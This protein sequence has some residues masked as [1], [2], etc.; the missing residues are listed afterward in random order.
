MV[1]EARRLLDE[2]IQSLEASIRFY[3]PEA[4]QERELWVVKSFLRNLDPAYPEDA[5]RS[6]V[7]DPPDVLFQDARFEVKEIMDAGR[8][9]HTEYR[10]ELE[11]ARAA[12]SIF[13]MIAPFTSKTI[14]I[15]AIFEKCLSDSMRL[16]TKYP[17][18]LRSTLDLLF[19]VNPKGVS[20][21]TEAPFPNVE[22]MTSQGWRSVSFLKGYSSCC[23]TTGPTAP[24]SVRA[25]LGKV[26]HRTWL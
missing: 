20:G 5:V 4:K 11:K 14:T 25:A 17:A 6:S 19:Y 2:Y 21:L 24:A 18:S 9:R 22:E 13:D 16:T 26:V 3:S 8:R 12:T 10:E 7:D 23:L 1:R 15:Q